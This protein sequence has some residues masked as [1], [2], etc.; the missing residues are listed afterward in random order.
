[1]EMLWFQQL[2]AARLQRRL[3]NTPIGAGQCS[4]ERNREQVFA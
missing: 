2:N 1:M 4:K 3:C